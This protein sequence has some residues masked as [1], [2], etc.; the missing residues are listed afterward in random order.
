MIEKLALKDSLWRTIAF[1]ICKDKMLSD[2]LVQEM[3]IKLHDCQKEINDF[4]VIRTI[5]NLFLDTIKQNNNVSIELFYNFEEINNTFEPTDYELA[6]INS[7]DKLPYLQNGL[8]KENYDLSVRQISEKYQYINY[9]LIHRELDKARKT[10]LGNDI[11]LYKNKRLKNGK[12]K[13]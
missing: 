10:I 8:L 13:K 2:D 11:D 1:K 5:R 7:C 12:K 9:G 4:Y 3:Y 6:I